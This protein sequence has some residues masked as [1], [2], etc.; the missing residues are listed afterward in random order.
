MIKEYRKLR[1]LTQQRLGD[2]IGFHQ[3]TISKHEK[4]EK[5]DCKTCEQIRH[6]IMRISEIQCK[7]NRYEE[8]YKLTPVKMVIGKTLT[9]VKKKNTFRRLCNVIKHFIW[10]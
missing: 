8:A 7:L 4:D 1:G 10:R 3:S 6:E 9:P 5:S 2:L